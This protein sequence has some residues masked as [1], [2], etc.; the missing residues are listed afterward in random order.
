LLSDPD[1][2]C[3]LKV[4]TPIPIPRVKDQVWPPKPTV[5]P[6]MC[7]SYRDWRRG[8]GWGEEYFVEHIVVCLKAFGDSQT[9][10][11]FWFTDGGCSVFKNLDAAREE[12]QRI[13]K[14]LGGTQCVRVQANQ[15]WASLN[16]SNYYQ[17]TLLPTGL[18]NETAQDC[19]FGGHCPSE[20]LQS[21]VCKSDTGELVWQTCCPNLLT[22]LGWRT[23]VE[24]RD[25]EN[26]RPEPYE[27]PAPNAPEAQP[28]LET[29]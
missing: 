13:T 19:N 21:A 27:P 26:S 7:S 8:H 22:P 2:P 10:N 28:G 12:V 3:D 29:P 14:E 9:C 16:N 11:D 18:C 23:W 15:C 20:A 4:T 25:C 6:K 1:A 5:D 24:G 17:F